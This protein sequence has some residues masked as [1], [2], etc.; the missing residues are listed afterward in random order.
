MRNEKRAHA[1][2]A[3]VHEL[4]AYPKTVTLS[5]AKGLAHKT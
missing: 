1:A 4:R 3:A 2:D 5:E